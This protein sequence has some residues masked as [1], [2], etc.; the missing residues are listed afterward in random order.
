M[1]TP[2]DWIHC[3]P[4]FIIH[5]Q[6][7]RYLRLGVGPYDADRHAISDALTLRWVKQF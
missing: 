1:I 4:A 5:C 3:L 6:E 7:F 2:H